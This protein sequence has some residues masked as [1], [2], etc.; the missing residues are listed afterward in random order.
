MVLSTGRQAQ[1]TRLPWNQSPLSPPTTPSHL[2][3]T[4]TR[5]SA[6]RA[7][8][9]SRGRWLRPE[10]SPTGGG[11]KGKG[12][13]TAAGRE[14]CTRVSWGCPPCCK[15]PSRARVSVGRRRLAPASAHP[16]ILSTALRPGGTRHPC[17]LSLRPALRPG[18]R[19]ATILSARR[20]WVHEPVR[21]SACFSTLLLSRPCAIPG[22][23]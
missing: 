16:S 7:L 6:P 21:L 19:E 20:S 18:A 22:D 5:P 9:L 4:G 12:R 23:A 17:R 3:P 15:R 1:V 11:L 2:A 10:T 14:G 13:A 8:Q